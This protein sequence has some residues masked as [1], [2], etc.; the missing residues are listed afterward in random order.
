MSFTRTIFMVAVSAMALMALPTSSGAQEKEQKEEC[1]CPSWAEVRVW[2]RA[3]LSHVLLQGRG[4]LGIYVRSEANAETDAV[5]AYVAGVAEGG[6]A[7]EAGIEE[8]DIITRLDGESLTS[9]GQEEE[10]GRSV[11]GM[12]LVE[13]AR[14]L[15]VGDTVEVEYVRDGETRTA[16]IVVG[17]FESPFRM[18]WAD[19]LPNT[20]R[21][22]GMMRR[23]KELPEVRLR[24]PETFAFRLGARLPGLELASLNPELGEYFGVEEG[25]LVVS[26]PE[27]SELGLKGGDVIQSIDGRSVRSPSHAMRILRSYEADEE[28]TFELIRKEKGI[29]VKGKVGGPVTDDGDHDL[30]IWH[31]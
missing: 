7:D 31:Y 12:R 13:R 4:R 11:P 18:L 26:V 27:D 22:E 19:S 1:V 20:P 6:P 24:G 14:T 9:G 15:E 25:V 23:F 3:D 16:R 21:I 5:G 30:R 2:P 10:E 17:E 8:G 29:T 28:V